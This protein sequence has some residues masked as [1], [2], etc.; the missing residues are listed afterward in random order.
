MLCA[1]GDR[2]IPIKWKCDGEFDCSDGSDEACGGK[3]FARKLQKKRNIHLL[4]L[5]QNSLNHAAWTIFHFLSVHFGYEKGK[6]YPKVCH[7]FPDLCYTHRE[8]DAPIIHGESAKFW[9]GDIKS[10]TTRD[11]M[12]MTNVISICVGNKAWSGF[13]TWLNAK[14]VLPLMVLGHREPSPL[15]LYTPKMLDKMLCMC[16]LV[17]GYFMDNGQDEHLSLNKLS[18]LQFALYITML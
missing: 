16:F 15:L 12:Y 9:H 14:Y 3:M 4:Y 8:K 7:C 17:W 10:L 2:C 6:T 5:S 11:D 1:N 18:C 13:C